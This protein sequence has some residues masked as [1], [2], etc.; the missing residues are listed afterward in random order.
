MEELEIIFD[1]FILISLSRH[2]QTLECNGLRHV[3]FPLC[4]Q[5]KNVAGNIM[6]FTLVFYILCKN[7]AIKDK[8]Y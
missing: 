6:I 2:S 5:Q 3:D 1:G 4:W 8:T 7:D